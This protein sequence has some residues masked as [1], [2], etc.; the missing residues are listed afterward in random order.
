MVLHEENK[1]SDRQLAVQT[2]CTTAI[3]R[4]G[5]LLANLL[6]SGPLVRP[7]AFAATLFDSPLHLDYRLVSSGV[8]GDILKHLLTLT[9]VLQQLLLW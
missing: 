1:S 7:Y 8:T 2:W 4:E 6:K 9:L 3:P 5:H